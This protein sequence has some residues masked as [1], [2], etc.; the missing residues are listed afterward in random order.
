MMCFLI[1]HD[2]I[3]ALL[4]LQ[5]SFYRC[6][7]D[8]DIIWSTWYKQILC[9]RFLASKS[10]TSCNH[11]QIFYNIFVLFDVKRNCDT[12]KRNFSVVVVLLHGK[13]GSKM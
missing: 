13:N 2:K 6:Q 10:T 7:G 1:R 12:Y 4:A 8:D 11:T 9:F 5:S 3:L